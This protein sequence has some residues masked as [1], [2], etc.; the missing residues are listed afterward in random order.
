ME[1][2]EDW[3][4]L[5]KW[6]DK[7]K[8]ENKEKFGMD[9][10]KFDIMNQNKKAKKVLNIFN[11]TGKIGFYLL[12]LIFVVVLYFAFNYIISLFSKVNANVNSIENDYNIKTILVSKDID[13]N[14]NGKYIFSLKNNKELQF[15]VLKK[16]GNIEDD[17]YDRSHKYYFEKWNDPD[18]EKFQVEEKIKNGLLNYKTYIEIEGYDDIAYTFS[19]MYKFADFCENDFCRSWDIYICKGDFIGYFSDNYGLTQEENIEYMQDRYLKYVE[20]KEM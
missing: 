14:G 3:E 17:F 6:E 19:L 12:I 18:K 7:V 8:R 16:Y 1:N 15:T 11:I 4:E 9:Y 10:E 13:N 2:K 20:N 5:Q